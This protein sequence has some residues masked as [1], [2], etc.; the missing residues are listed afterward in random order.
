MHAHEEKAVAKNDPGLKYFIDL[1]GVFGP[2]SYIFCFPAFYC[3]H[4]FFIMSAV[5]VSVT[6]RAYMWAALF[7]LYITIFD[8]IVFVACLYW[9][10]L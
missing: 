4:F 3:N 2:S 10:K 1:S 9:V 7:Q 6:Y 5:L 8:Q